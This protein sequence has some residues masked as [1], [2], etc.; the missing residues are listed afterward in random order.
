[1]RRAQPN[2]S[3][4]I[5]SWATRFMRSA[6]VVLSGFCAMAPAVSANPNP[7]APALDYESLIIVPLLGDRLPGHT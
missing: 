5:S 4:Q 3:Y 7:C 2:G 1:M 6:A